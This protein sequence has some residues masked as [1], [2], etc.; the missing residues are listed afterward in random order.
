LDVEDRR[1]RRGR[2]HAETLSLSLSL[3]RSLSPS[4]PRATLVTPT[5][6][7]PVRDNISL[8][9]LLCSIL[10]QPIWAG[11]R[12]NKFTGRLTVLAGPK[13]RQRVKTN[14]K[15]I[16]ADDTVIYFTEVRFLRTYFPLRWSQ[17]LGLFQP[18]S[19]LKRSPRPSEPFSSIKWD[20]KSTT[21]TTT[22]W[23][24]LF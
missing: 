6:S 17:R 5:T 22:T 4:L 10:H 1:G 23:C 19:S 18:F 2:Q 7:T 9:S 24:L 8:I 21:R 16:R 20:T 12:S 14:Y 13:R 15:R 11:T 3:S